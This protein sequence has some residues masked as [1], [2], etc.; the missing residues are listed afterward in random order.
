[1]FEGFD[2]ELIVCGTPRWASD[3]AERDLPC[4][5]HGHPRT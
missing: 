5:L 2:L 1:M 4:L 3:M